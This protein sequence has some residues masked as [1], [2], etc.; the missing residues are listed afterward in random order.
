MRNYLL[1]VFYFIVPLL[2]IF[3]SI[4]L[5]IVNTQNAFNLKAKFIRDNTDI[6]YLFLGSS[7]TA[8][9]V[10]LSFLDLKSSNLAYA[11]QDYQL[12]N[13]L[14]FKYIEQLT[15]LKYVFLEMNYHSLENVREPYYFRM[16]WYYYHHDIN[17]YNF[18][19]IDKFSLFHTS[20]RYFL[21]Y[22][23]TRISSKTPKSIY[24]KFGFQTNNFPGL[25]SSL[26][27]NES[28]ISSTSNT[29]L[30]NQNTEIIEENYNFNVAKI[31][32][33]ID[34]CKEK[35]ITIIFLKTPI[36]HTYRDIYIGKNILRRDEFVNSYVDGKSILLF[37]FEKDKR[38][39][40]NDFLNDDHLN[41]M[42][43]KKLTKII[44][45]LLIENKTQ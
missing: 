39:I 14:F 24:N 33:I 18:S 16:P 23:V 13:A 29:R 35:K 36:F 32:S 37:D 41:P 28:L 27:Y 21:R 10:N 2:V 22:M 12:N 9:A 42:G 45:E 1:K 19:L 25:F 6:E 44:N 26:N 34:Y 11:A 38:F 7:H 43:A 30:F 20:P 5:F 8:G 15:Q 40:V 4:E 3:F 17:L 31:K